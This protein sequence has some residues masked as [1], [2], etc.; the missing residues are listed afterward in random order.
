MMVFAAR[1]GSHTRGWVN[2][3]RMASERPTIPGEPASAN[4][5]TLNQCKSKPQISATQMLK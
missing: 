5:L 1:T 2:D 3:R 4:R